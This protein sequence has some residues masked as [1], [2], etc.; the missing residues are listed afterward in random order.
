MPPNGYYLK[1]M[2]CTRCW[3]DASDVPDI[4]DTREADMGL[5]TV[6]FDSR[7]SERVMYVTPHKRDCGSLARTLHDHRSSR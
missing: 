6:H 7:D 5:A 1:Q 2:A 4:P 3:A